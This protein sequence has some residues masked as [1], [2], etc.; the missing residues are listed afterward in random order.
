MKKVTILASGLLLGAF[1]CG[2]L[3]AQDNMMRSGLAANE[4]AKANPSV[5]AGSSVAR[6]AKFSKTTARA[7]KDFKSRFINA[8]DEQ[9]SQTSKGSSVYFTSKGFKTRAYYDARG[10]WQG[11]LKYC[12]ES[13]LP[14]YIRDVI[15]RNYYDLAIT[16]VV[17]GEVPEHKAYIVNVEDSKTLKVVRVNEDGEM[18]VMQDLSKVK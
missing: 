5:S 9:W 16:S 4:P 8:E 1:I 18:D 10:N 3:H 2:Q 11:S 12:N 13:E 6:T 15:R 17:I 7:I 14:H